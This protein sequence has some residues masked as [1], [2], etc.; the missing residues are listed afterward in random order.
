MGKH[1]RKPVLK[2]VENVLAGVFSGICDDDI[3][4]TKKV[5]RQALAK[6]QQECRQIKKSSIEQGMMNDRGP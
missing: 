6:A 5:L 2:V 3:S 4:R 1:L